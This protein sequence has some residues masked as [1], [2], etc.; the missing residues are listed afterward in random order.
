MIAFGNEI[1]YNDG[2]VLMMISRLLRSLSVL[3]FL[4]AISMSQA[5]PATAAQRAGV[6]PSKD[7]GTMHLYTKIGSCKFLNGEGRLE[8]S[9][10]GSLL[11]SQFKGKYTITGNLV[12]QYNSPEHGREL[13]YGKGTIVL[14]GKW[15]GL[16]W[17][18]RDFTAHWYGAGIARLTGEY[19]ASPTKPGTFESG[20]VWADDISKRQAWPAVGSF[21]TRNPPWK[22]I[23]PKQVVPK[24]R[25]EPTPKPKT[26]T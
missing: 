11:L 3:V 25:S 1:G 4:F 12:R 7:F 2:L 8:I 6:V 21:E 10:S 19:Y 9:Y 22:V 5:Q 16:Q 23:V 14:T 24:R 26:T 17:F 15:R 20:W 18:G 13:Y